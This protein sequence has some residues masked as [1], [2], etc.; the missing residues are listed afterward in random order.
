MRIRQAI[1]C[2]LSAER[3]IGPHK[4]CAGH[5]RIRTQINQFFATWAVIDAAQIIAEERGVFMAEV[6]LARVTGQP[7]VSSVI[8]GAHSISQ[9]QTNLRAAQLH[10]TAAQAD[11]LDAASDPYPTDFPTAS[12]AWTAPRTQPGS[13]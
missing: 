7:A 4:N 13:H 11:A 8:L 10:H 9:L 1:R 2:A 3:R 6:A 12:W 5:G